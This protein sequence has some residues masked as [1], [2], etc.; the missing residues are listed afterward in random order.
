MS[1]VRNTVLYNRASAPWARRVGGGVVFAKGGG[2]GGGIYS[3]FI[4]NRD[5]LQQ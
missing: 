2:R 4:L 3:V 5:T 1:G